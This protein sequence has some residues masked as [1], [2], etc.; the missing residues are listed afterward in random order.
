[1]CIGLWQDSV[2]HHPHGTQD[3]LPPVDH[4]RCQPDF[5]HS[6]RADR[7]GDSDEHEYPDPKL[8]KHAACVTSPGGC[9]N[10]VECAEPPADIR[11]RK[12]DPAEDTYVVHQFDRQI[13]GRDQSPGAPDR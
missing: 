6:H 8:S 2:D 12:D 3:G 4:R 11:R 5:A 13:D 1:M 10:D 9:R 7:N